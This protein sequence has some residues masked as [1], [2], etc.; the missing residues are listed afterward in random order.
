VP[1]QLPAGVA[2]RAHRALDPL[3]SLIYFG[4]EADEELGAVGLR[5]GRMCYFASR[6]AP[7]GPVA[8]A[9]TVATFYNFNPTLVAKYLPRAW[10]LA[11]IEDILAARL[12]AAERGLR[13]CLG[14]AA[15]GEEISQAATLARAAVTDLPAV[16]RPLFAGHAALPW[17][18]EPLLQL[19]HAIT[20]E[21]EF[22]GDGHI[23]ALLIHELSGLDALITHTATGRGFSVAAAK[24]TRGW[25]DYQWAAGEESLRERGILDASGGLTAAGAALRKAIEVD[26][27][28]LAATTWLRLTDDERTRLIDI[29]KN[30]SRI[31]YEAGAFAAVSAG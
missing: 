7:M 17:P 27:D 14:P 29:G 11:S 16:G 24:A 18:E 13:R 3:H 10:G 25:S 5:P 30:L 12:R 4:P 20:L 23:A 8:A 26:T 19:W 1:E 28:R 31:A 21:R 2:A 22:R 6:S 15:E 9:V